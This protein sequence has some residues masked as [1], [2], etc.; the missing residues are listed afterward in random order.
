MSQTV[1]QGESGL[2]PKDHPLVTI[3]RNVGTRY[4]AILAEMLIGL[5]MLPFNLSH[6]GQEAY[7]LWMLTAG[8]TIHFSVLDMGYGS[9]VVKFIAQYRAHRDGRALNEIASTMFFVYAAIG[10][11]AY[12]VVIALAFNIDHFFRITPE[13]AQVGKW[14]LLII[15]LNIACNFPFS[16]FGGVIDGFQRYDRNNIVAIV[17]SA[18]VAL[19]NALVLFL[20]YG[21][22]PLV[23]AT[24]AVRLLTYLV[25]RMN[26]YRIY[27][28]LSVRAAFFRKSQLRKVTRFSVYSSVID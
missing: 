9:A 5:V 6:L 21:L 27:P 22:V 17:S 24:T 2:A 7:G 19:A 4:L 3:A 8:V 25:Y 28:G 1:E 11:A 10:V 13:Q 18:F 12:L 15:G 23:A 16:I 26:A 14:I 20:G